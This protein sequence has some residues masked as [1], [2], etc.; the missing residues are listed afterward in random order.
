MLCVLCQGIEAHPFG[1]DN[2][3]EWTATIHG[4]HETDWEG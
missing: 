3:F 1:D 4:L 2:Y